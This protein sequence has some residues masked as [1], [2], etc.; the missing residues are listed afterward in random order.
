[1]I[2]IVI[3]RAHDGRQSGA[4]SLQIGQDDCDL[5]VQRDRRSDVEQISGDHDDID[6]RGSGEHPVELAQIEMKV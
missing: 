3:P 2:E 6:I 1:M 5:G 4:K